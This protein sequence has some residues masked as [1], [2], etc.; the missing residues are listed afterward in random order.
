MGREVYCYRFT[1]GVSMSAVEE[2][3]LLAVLAAEC[4]HGSAVVRLEA[5]FCLD[6][7]KRSC[8]VDATTAVGRDLARIFAGFVTREFG[9][10]AFRVERPR[11]G[12]MSQDEPKAAP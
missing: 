11:N 3:L 8:V 5:V 1:S 10:D 9:E 7:Q 6:E 2:L 12:G 4:L